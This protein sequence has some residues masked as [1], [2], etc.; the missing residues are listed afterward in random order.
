[1]L[2]VFLV[3]ALELRPEPWAAIATGFE[4]FFSGMLT[5]TMFALM[6][7]RTDRSIGAT[8]Y[9]FLAT[10]EVLGKAALSLSSGAIAQHLGY[11]IAF[12]IAVIVALAWSAF[13]P[14]LLRASP[15]A[16]A[17]SPPSA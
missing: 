6:M 1:M 2:G 4:H 7:S 8:H 11:P 15:P 5:T 3:A 17:H 9:T 13:A 10:V 16:P 12:A 14:A